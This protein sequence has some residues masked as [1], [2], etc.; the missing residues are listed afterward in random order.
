[1][2]PKPIESEKKIWPYAAVH[3]PASPSAP[4]SGVKSASRP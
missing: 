2:I 1:M 3:T 4:Q